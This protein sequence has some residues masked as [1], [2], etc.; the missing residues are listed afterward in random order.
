MFRRH[1]FRMFPCRLFRYSHTTV[2][3]L[4]VDYLH[5]PAKMHPAL[6]LLRSVLRHCHAARI[7]AAKDTKQE[8]AA[9]MV[10][11]AT[12]NHGRATEAG[13]QILTQATHV[14][15]SEEGP[16]DK[17]YKHGIDMP[18]YY[19]QLLQPLTQEQSLQQHKGCVIQAPQQEVPACAVPDAGKGPD[20]QDIA[21][22]LPLRYPIASQREVD[23]AG[24][25]YFCSSAACACSAAITALRMATIIGGRRRSQSFTTPAF[26][27]A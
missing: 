27:L 8:I 20:D 16:A 14:L 12:A 5:R 13:L 21:D 7:H 11:V 2:R 15:N 25:L 24:L 9:D 3:L 10:E 1:M 26:I 18:Q 22:P 6:F 4:L 23:E 19:R 17:H